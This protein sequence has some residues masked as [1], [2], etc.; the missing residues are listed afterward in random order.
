MSNNMC[1][2]IITRYFKLTFL[3]IAGVSNDPT[4]KFLDPRDTERVKSS[5]NDYVST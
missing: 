1:L 5:F 3:F 4:G 2:T